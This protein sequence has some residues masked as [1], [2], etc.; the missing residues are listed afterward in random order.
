MPAT[1]IL[2]DK[3]AF[4]A[5]FVEIVIWQVPRPVSPS[6]HPFKYRLVYVVQGN[7]MMGYDN[8]RGKGDHRHLGDIESPYAF[9]DV[10]TLLR[11]FWKDV[12]EMQR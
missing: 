1:P 4:G 8:E 5:G 6:G 9:V 3:Q 11:D 10:A 12:M 7:R 2:S